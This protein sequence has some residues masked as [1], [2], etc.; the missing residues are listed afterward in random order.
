MGG[1]GWRSLNGSRKQA[2]K[3][4]RHRAQEPEGEARD[5]P[6]RWGRSAVSELTLVRPVSGPLLEFPSRGGRVCLARA[7]LLRVVGLKQ[8]N[9]AQAGKEPGVPAGRAEVHRIGGDGSREGAHSQVLESPP[10]NPAARET[11]LRCPPL[12]T[13]SPAPAVNFLPGRSGISPPTAPGN[14]QSPACC[15]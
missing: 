12:P 1:E 10:C 14:A 4:P 15:C 2:W 11:V 13:A 6:R 3:W 7:S 8:S 5:R 9:L